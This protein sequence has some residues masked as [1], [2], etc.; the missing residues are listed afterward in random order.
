ML[1]AY[2]MPGTAPGLYTTIHEMRIKA[3]G[4]VTFSAC[5]S[6]TKTMIRE[7]SHLIL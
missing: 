7:T 5:S 2:S 6:Y 3:S 4:Q 1:S